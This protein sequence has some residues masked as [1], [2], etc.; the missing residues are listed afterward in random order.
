[1]KSKSFTARIRDDERS[2]PE[3]AQVLSKVLPFPV[4]R[5]TVHNWRIGRLPPP[6]KQKMVLEAM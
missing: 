6:W 1:M 4:S 5:R 3:L 2:A